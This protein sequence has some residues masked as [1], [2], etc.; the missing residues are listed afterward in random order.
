MWI[1]DF[2]A[3]HF[4]YYGYMVSKFFEVAYTVD[5]KNSNDG[6]FNKGKAAWEKYWKC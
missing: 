1:L 4:V 5:Q 3:H 6:V 2:E